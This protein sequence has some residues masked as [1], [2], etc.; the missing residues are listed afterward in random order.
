[1]TPTSTT[2]S[3]LAD[4]PIGQRLN[5]RS[6]GFTLVELLIALTILVTL[7]AMLAPVMLPSPGRALRQAGS[8]IAT[9]LRE[10][11]RHAQAEQARR[12]F[13]MDTQSGSYGI[14]NVQRQRV[15]PEGMSAQ[16][17][18]AESLLTGDTAGAIDFFPDG[19]STGG[20]VVL[21]LDDQ[22]LQVDIEWLTGRIRV[23]E[24]D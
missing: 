19:S 14:E 18:T 16:L 20:R 3:N 7:T 13:L 8:E 17:T 2:G 5:G 1:M 10:T 4:A 21:G 15:L 23:S 6:T 24:V 11:R 12:R 22:S 9:T